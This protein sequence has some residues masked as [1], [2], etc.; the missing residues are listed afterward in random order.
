MGWLYAL[1]KSTGASLWKF[2]SGE[3]AYNC[4]SG[5]EDTVY[6][7]SRDRYLYALD[8]KSGGMNWKFR[9]NMGMAISPLITENRIYVGSDGIYALDKKGGTVWSYRASETVDAF[10]FSCTP[11]LYDNNMYF[12][13]FDGHLRRLDMDGNPV[14]AFKSKA[15]RGV[16]VSSGAIK[17][18]S[19]WDEGMFS[20][21]E[22]AVEIAPPESSTVIEKYG[23]GDI[24]AIEAQI[25]NPYTDVVGIGAYKSLQDMKYVEGSA[26]YSEKDN[27]KKKDTENIEKLFRL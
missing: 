17:P 14:W 26:S 2:H 25:E 16:T 9:A 27:K 12:T 8:K 6:F 15:P 3:E 18:M 4:I 19:W 7:G 1:D 23:V 5:A 21:F 24:F 11:V 13:S 10:S 22:C 20:I